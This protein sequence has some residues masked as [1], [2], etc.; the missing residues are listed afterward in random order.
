[1]LTGVFRPAFAEQIR[2]RLVIQLQLYIRSNAVENTMGRHTMVPAQVHPGAER[3][4]YKICDETPESPASNGSRDPLRGLE[5]IAHQ[6][7]CAQR[8]AVA[9]Y[10]WLGSRSGG[11][12]PVTGFGG[13]VLP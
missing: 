12:M 5:R 4:G 9:G 11:S 2:L 10:R 7:R 3:Y 8:Q 1:M 13:V 6:P